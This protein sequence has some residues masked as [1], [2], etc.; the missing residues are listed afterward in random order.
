MPIINAVADSDVAVKVTSLSKRF[1]NGTLALDNVSLEVP[2]GQVLALI[3]LSGSGKSTLLRTLNGLHAPTGGKVV[4]QGTDV[5]AANGKSLRK[6]RHHIGFVFQQFGL[7]GRATCME[8]VLVGSLG[9]LRGPRLGVR[10]YPVALRRKAL[11]QLERVGLSEHAF[12]RA[13]T[14]S[15]GQMQ[16]V[17]IARSLMQEPS[18]LL[19]DEPVASLDPESANQVLDLIL[20]IAREDGM[21]VICTL[22]QVELALG[23]SDRIVGLRAGQVV[24][25]QMNAQ[26]SQE[27]VMEVY[28]ATG[29]PMQFDTDDALQSA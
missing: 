6:L 17:A 19:A 26:L 29:T 8:N 10:S 18:V 12:Q 16:R 25:D 23:W 14:L 4:V 9:S 1:P 27:Q 11:E 7:V 13:D 5:S 21:T 20:R 2:R 24:L 22:H 3:G 15:G 28:R